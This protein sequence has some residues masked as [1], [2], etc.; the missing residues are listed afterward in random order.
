MASTRKPGRPRNP[1]P[2]PEVMP[3]HSK[4]IAEQID[5]ILMALE[6]PAIDEETRGIFE[7][8]TAIALARASI[9]QKAKTGWP[10]EFTL[11]ADHIAYAARK[12]IDRLR[13]ESAFNKFRNNHQAKGNMFANWD[14]AWRSWIDREE[15]YNNGRDQDR[16]RIDDRL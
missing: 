7:G 11:T 1:P 6:V 3:W 12:G 15:Q 8:K 14:A 4:A 2:P 9:G 16:N 5:E 13:A 10:P